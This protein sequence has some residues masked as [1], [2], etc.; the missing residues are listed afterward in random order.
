MI[1]CIIV[2]DE[3][4]AQEVI[5]MH[6]AGYPQFELLGVYRNTREAAEALSK[7]NVDLMFLDIRLPGMTGL[8]FLRQLVHPP[9]VVLTTAYAEYA[10]E[11]YEFN[12]IDYLLKPISTERFAK[13]VS[14]I[15]DVKLFAGNAKADNPSSDHLFIRSSSKFFR[16][17]YED[18]QYIEGMKDYLKVHLDG[19]TLITHQTMAEMEKI[20]PVTKF[21]RIHRSYIISISRIKS[22]FGNSVEL[23]NK[24]LPVG[25]NYKD[26]L[27]ELV[28]M[29]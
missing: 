25:I 12:V 15:E 26:G 22:V 21:I 23:T 2:E 6:L 14:K 28:G 19:S 1:R 8:Q 16:V 10:L 13:A 11:S 27:M 18:I 5:K 17:R 4:L 29:K 9:L 24:T 7:N 20:L 3:E